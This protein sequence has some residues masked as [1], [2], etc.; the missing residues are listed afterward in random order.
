MGGSEGSECGRAALRVQADLLL[1]K[2]QTAEHRVGS[3]THQPL[4]VDWR[5]SRSSWKPGVWVRPGFARS[6]Q[7]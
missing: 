7:T 5:C 6:T 3:T 1:A 4:H 2:M